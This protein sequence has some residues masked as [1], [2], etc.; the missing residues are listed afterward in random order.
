MFSEYARK[1]D[2]MGTLTTISKCI[3]EVLCM[4]ENLPV[5]QGGIVNL[6]RCIVCQKNAIKKLRSN[7]IVFLSSI[8]A[9]YFIKFPG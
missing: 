7:L 2:G 5:I 9:G 6:R 8:N 4:F 1:F 3:L